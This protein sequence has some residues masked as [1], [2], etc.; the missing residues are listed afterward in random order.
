MHF[1]VLTGV[2][3]G[4]LKL[5]PA[6]SMH[7]DKA[8]AANPSQTYRDISPPFGKRVLAGAPFIFSQP[9]REIKEICGQRERLS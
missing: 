7:P 8:A 1:A 6:V 3:E 5:G 4:P 2:P 9:E